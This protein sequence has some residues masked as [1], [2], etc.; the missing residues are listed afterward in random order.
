[1]AV[2]APD[3]KH[4]R[5]SR[6]KP[7]ARRRREVLAQAWKVVRVSLVAGLAVAGLAA[8]GRA[9][10]RSSYFTVQRLTVTG[11][12]RLSPGEA[13][14]LLHGLRGQNILRADLEAWQDR[15][16]R[17]PWVRSAELHRV[18]PSTVEVEIVERVPLAIGR[19]G[20]R[21]HLVDDRGEIIDE[22]GPE[23]AELDLPIVDGLVSGEK[24]QR[25]ARAAL[26]GRLVGALSARPE[27]LRMVSQID[28]VDPRDAVAI[29]ENDPARVH[30]GDREFIARLE[31]YLE[32]RPAL[33]ARVPVIDYVDLR[34][35]SRV[36]VRPAADT[37]APAVM[38]STVREGTAFR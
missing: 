12:E 36:F 25:W 10:V 6:A 11:N 15:L 17:S 13:A 38:A 18:L 37:G 35:E 7:A 19:A 5:R 4:F 20:D 23:Y 2:R 30:L 22:Y 24:D 21:L 28:V 1:M 16:T 34:F 29:L 14:D 32:L 9:L 33:Q 31:S 3:D 26:V 8:A 27:L